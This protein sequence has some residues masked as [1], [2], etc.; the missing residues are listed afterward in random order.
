MKKDSPTK[1]LVVAMAPGLLP[2][3][4]KAKIIDGERKLLLVSGQSGSRG[5]SGS[6]Y[7]YDLFQQY[8]LLPEDVEAEEFEQSMHDGLFTCSFAK[9]SD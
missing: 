6:T 7:S 5:A 2:H 3:E 4:I 1:F 8:V 9:K